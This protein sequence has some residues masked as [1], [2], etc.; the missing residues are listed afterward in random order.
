MSE[1]IS[2]KDSLPEIR[3]EVLVYSYEDEINNGMYVARI[4]GLNWNGSP[5]WLYSY[6]CGNHVPNVTH[7]MELP[8]A[9]KDE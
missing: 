6:C 5:S 8:E 7:W 4:D 1:W 9:P 3:K 2:V